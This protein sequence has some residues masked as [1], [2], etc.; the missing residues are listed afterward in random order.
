[1]KELKST[2]AEK[3][4]APQESRESGKAQTPDRDPEAARYLRSY[5]ETLNQLRGELSTPEKAY[6]SAQK[7]FEEGEPSETSG[8]LVHK[9]YWS[10]DRLKQIIGSSRGEDRV[11]WA[12]V[13][14]PAEFAWRALLDQTG[15]YLQEQWGALRLEVMDLSPGSKASKILAFVNANAGPFLEARRNVYVPRSLQGE[16]LSF[17][18]AFLDY[19]SRSRSV[20][21]EELGKVDPPRQIVGAL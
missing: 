21:P 4:K 2:P 6:R 7:T 11:L 19:L 3:E 12:I 14:R 9:A 16:G 15:L 5:L 13:G 20:S 8:S 1:L 18:R 10:L 17:N